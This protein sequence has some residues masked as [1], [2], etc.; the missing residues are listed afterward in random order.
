VSPIRA[1]LFDLDGTLVDSLETIAG[2][3]AEA[4][5]KHGYEV[6]EATIVPLIGPPMD[7]MAHDLTGAPMEVTRK[8]YG[9]YLVIYHRDYIERT[10]PHEG[11]QALLQRLRAAGVR[12]GVVTNKI[13]EGGRLMVRVQAWERFFEVIVGQDTAARP[14]PAPDSALY[15]LSALG[16]PPAEAAF[17]GDT[18]FDMNCGRDAGCTMVIGVLGARDEAFLRREGA[19][20]V[21]GHLDEV[22]PLLLGSEVQR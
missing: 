13:E 12:L 1:A 16:V 17:V 15:A 3:M 20:H 10:P 14:K 18:E 22:A 19:T 7:V 6:S 11:A 2:A 5:R 4:I 8:M 9:D 21:V